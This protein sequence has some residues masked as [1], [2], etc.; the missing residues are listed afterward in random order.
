MFIV[1][2]EEQD[3]T[4]LYSCNGLI[5]SELIY[6]QGIPLYGKGLKGENYFAKTKAL[7]KAL[8]NLPFWMQMFAHLDKI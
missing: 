8:K 1:N 6:N 3:L 4:K 7:R 2:P 5:A